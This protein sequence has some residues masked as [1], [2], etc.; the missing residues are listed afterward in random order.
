MMQIVLIILASLI[1]QYV[2]WKEMRHEH[3]SSEI[4][5]FALLLNLV[6]LV[7]LV[8]PYLGLIGGLAF[9]WAWSKR[10]KWDFWEWLDTLIPLSL[11][12]A[13]V[14]SWSMGVDGWMV[15]TV[16]LSGWLLVIVLG[17]FYRQFNWYKSGRL[18][19]MGIIALGWWGVVQLVVANLS[20]WAV[21]SFA[22]IVILS[23][24]TLYLRSGR[25][26]SEDLKFI[27]PSKRKPTKK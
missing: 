3:E 5:T 2:V 7:S 20:I 11:L 21:Y 4:F 27:W 18:G 25:K 12:V 14:V 1:S 15:A 8:W 19:F 6:A 24:V 22:W 9:L 16:A 13:F 10:Q 17:L 23:A 26:L